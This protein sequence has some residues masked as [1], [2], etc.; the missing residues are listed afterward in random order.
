VGKLSVTSTELGANQLEPFGY[1]VIISSVLS[2]ETLSLPDHA[3]MQSRLEGKCQTYDA[4]V[5]TT[6]AQVG[7]RLLRFR[8]ADSDFALPSGTKPIIA[9]NRPVSILDLRFCG[10]YCGRRNRPP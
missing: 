8:R 7:L 2:K 1:S 6:W 9:K 5:G 4:R 10:D 3:R